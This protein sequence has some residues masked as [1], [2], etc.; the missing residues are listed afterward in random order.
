MPASLK[1]S[2]ETSSST[3]DQQSNGKKA[4]INTPLERYY[5]LNEA[6]KVLHE[7][8][9]QNPDQRIYRV[10]EWNYDFT[11]IYQPFVVTSRDQLCEQFILDCKTYV[12]IHE[13]YPVD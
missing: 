7:T 12:N 2:R 9:N 8:I 6:K 4:R 11:K 3:Q 1:R 10:E 5:T 13:Y